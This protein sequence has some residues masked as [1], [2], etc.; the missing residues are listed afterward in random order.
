MCWAHGARCTSMRMRSAAP[1]WHLERSPR[2]QNQ[3]P[4]LQSLMGCRAAPARSQLAAMMP[5]ADASPFFGNILLKLKQCELKLA[6]EAVADAARG[7]G[8][9]AYICAR[10]AVAP[11][12]T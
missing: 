9:L 5:R 1:R 7:F 6:R 8:V 2:Q 3:K 10:R 12:P 11:R 4:W